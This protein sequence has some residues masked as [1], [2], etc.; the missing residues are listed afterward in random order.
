[1]ILAFDMTFVTTFGPIGLSKYW[2]VSGSGCVWEQTHVCEYVWE[3][4]WVASVCFF[5]NAFGS[6]FGARLHSTF[7]AAFELHV[8]ATFTRASK[9]LPYDVDACT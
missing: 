3:C 4:V 7:G 1:M 6:A 5:I 9:M 2:F 8:W